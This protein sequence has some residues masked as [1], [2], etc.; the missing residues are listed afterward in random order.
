MTDRERHRQT[1]ASGHLKDMTEE[2]LG[3]QEQELQAR[4]HRRERRQERQQRGRGGDDTSS[5]REQ[6]DN[7]H[8]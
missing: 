1:D 5:R 8:P 3:A 4:Q 6:G 2:T 7:D